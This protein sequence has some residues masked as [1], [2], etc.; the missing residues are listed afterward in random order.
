MTNPIPT[1]K[2]LS[3]G[4][5]SMTLIHYGA[6]PVRAVYDSA[7]DYKHF[8]P[9]GLW[10]S[11]LGDH[12]WREW[13]TSESFRDVDSQVQTKVILAEDA[14]ILHLSDKWEIDF[15]TERFRKDGDSRNIDWTRV[16]AEYDGIIIAPY[17]W[18][19]RMSDHCIWYY[20]WDCAAGCI[21]RGRAVERLEIANA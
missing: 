5:R 7:Q 12:D 13:C 15:F 14:N 10:V 20:S 8:K 17:C 16:Q 19:R 18:E 6:E 1:E 21:W 4:V 9:V 3:A 11:V 2:T